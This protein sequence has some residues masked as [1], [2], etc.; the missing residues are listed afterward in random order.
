[1]MSLLD[2]DR[3][4]DLLAELR[5]PELRRDP[6]PLLAALREH[7]P[8]HRTDAGFYLVSRYADA[9]WVL[10]NTGTAFRSPDPASLGRHFPRGLQHPSLAVQASTLPMLNE[11][12]HARA[13]RLLGQAFTPRSVRKFRERTALICERLL[14]SLAGPL[15]DGESVNMHDMYS[16]PESLQGFGEFLGIPEEDRV[17]L[18]ER[19]PRMYESLTL[20]PEDALATADDETIWLKNYFRDL[21]E[22]RRRHP[23]D[24]LLSALTRPLTGPSGTDQLDDDELFAMLWLLW[25]GGVMP[26]AAGID[27]GILT[28]LRHPEMGKWLLGTESENLAYADEALRHDGPAVFT[29]V[30]RIATVDVELSG[31]ILPAGSDVRPV[32]AA[33]DRDPS[34]FADPD[35]FDPGRS[36]P[37]PSLALGHGMH[38]CAGGQFARVVVATTLS[39]LHARFPTLRGSGKPRWSDA[40]VVARRFPVDIPVALD[41]GK[42]SKGPR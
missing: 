22:E 21:V 40:D 27:H 7:D 24:D 4:V 19:V 20:G 11:P 42:G 23:Q 28:M 16:V 18:A 13:R 41:T 32:L 12:A 38:N 2:Q 14:D 33:A 6:H 31:V 29:P 37:S 39:T 3:P 9:V 30:P 35:R 8:V 15:G 10:K 36:G 17:E 34:V 1:M 25:K 26:I 5:R